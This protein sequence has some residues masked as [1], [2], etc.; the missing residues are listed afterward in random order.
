MQNCMVSKGKESSNW[1]HLKKQER[2]E[3]GVGR[4]G[5]SH[6]SS[7]K[8]GRGEEREGEGR[9]GKE[10]GVL[11]RGPGTITD[12]HYAMGCTF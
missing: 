5:G 1:T 9:R 3:R 2:P 7:S 4:V 8:K 10:R 11:R 12:C 6:V